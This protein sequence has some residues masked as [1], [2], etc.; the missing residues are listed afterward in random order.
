MYSND[1][2]TDNDVRRLLQ[3]V[4]QVRE[5][6]EDRCFPAAVLTGL[7]EMIPCSEIGFQLTEP[8]RQAVV[9]GVHVYDDTLHD[10]SE[11][12]PDEDAER[13]ALFW[14]GYWQVGGCSYPLDTGDYTSVLRR[15]DRISDRAF[16]ATTT[17]L[18]MRLAGV[19]HEVMVS[20]P[21]QGCVH[22]RLLLF[23][24]DGYDFTERE[25]LL[26]RIFRPHLVELYELQQR[27]LQDQPDLTAR[28]WQILSIVATGASNAQVAR[29]LAIS[30]G[31]VRKHLENVFLRLEVS[32]RTE[33]V[34]RTR[35]L[36]E[37]SPPRRGELA[38]HGAGRHQQLTPPPFIFR[39]TAAALEGSQPRETRYADASAS[40]ACRASTDM[41]AGAAPAGTNGPA[42]CTS[43][44]DDTF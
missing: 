18:Y 35:A 26:L 4:D 1:T 25:V 44:G 9:D 12:A 29:A 6:P 34:A 30:Q 39:T 22:R 3:I 31:T 36:L 10:L 15:S 16:A 40:S 19:R 8:H 2:V 37:V 20:L 21:P 28:Q 41:H 23:R 43:G 33:A 38:A 14:E 5:Q 24:N 13:E 7:L 42:S 27:R 32:S 17:G 11:P